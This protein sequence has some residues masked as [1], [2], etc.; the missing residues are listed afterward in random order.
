EMEVV[1]V[2]WGISWLISRLASCLASFDRAFAL[3]GYV[4]D[5]TVVAEDEE[6]VEAMDVMED[7][8]ED[9]AGD[10]VEAEEM[11]ETEDEAMD[12]TE[13]MDVEVLDGSG[14]NHMEYRY[15]CTMEIIAVAATMTTMV[16]A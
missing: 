12:E 16:M 11:D 4:R 5:T 3:G 13:A 15:K 7:E 9:E 1:V 14:N 2:S 6:E 8:T 10:E